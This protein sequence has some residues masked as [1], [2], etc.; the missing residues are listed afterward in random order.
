MRILVVGAGSVGG[1]FGARLAAAGREVTFLVREKRAE[2]LHRDG[3][4]VVALNGDLTTIAPKTITADK[5][6]G[7][8][9]VIL[10]AVKTYGL[11]AAM[12]DF[13]PAVGPETMILPLLN[14]ICHLD[15]LSTRFSAHNVLGGLSHISSDLD[16]EGRIKLLAHFEDLVFGE[17][18]G[19][20]TPRI[21][22]L[23]AELSRA[24][25]DDELVFNVEALMW[26]KWV[27]L[28][29]S[30]VITC[31]LRGAI[32]DVIAVPQGHETALAVIAECAAVA[33]AEGHPISEAAMKFTK[34]RLTAAGSKFTASMYRDLQKGAAVEVDN[35]L[36]D[37]LKRGAI[38]GL[39][40]PTLRAACV[41]LGVYMNARG[42]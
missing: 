8:Y 41:Q 39:D 3:L 13:A 35:V 20:D 12:E 22:A 36:G 10:L 27:M 2:Q 18:D 23:A 14:G 21:R 26:E 19:T 1:F 5:M 32:G 7:P 30:A 40:T 6:D 42:R 11:E 15:M 17:L 28:S 29:A 34:D 16:S 25:F 4:R 38:R 9:D 37:L 24:G 31:L 33:A